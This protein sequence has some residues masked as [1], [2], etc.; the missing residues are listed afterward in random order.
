MPLI[1]LVLLIF[2]IMPAPLFLALSA[3]MYS[4]DHTGWFWTFF[5]IWLIH[6]HEDL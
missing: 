2:L 6:V 5:V 1:V 3:I 4:Y